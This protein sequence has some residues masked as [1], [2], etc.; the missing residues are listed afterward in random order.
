MNERFTANA[1]RAFDTAERL[2]LKTGGTIG[3]EHLLMGICSV[4]NSLGAYVLREYGVTVSTLSGIFSPSPTNIAFLSPKVKSIISGA[5]A[6]AIK[7]SNGYIDVEHLLMALLKSADCVA[8]RVL[9]TLGIDKEEVFNTLLAKY[10]GESGEFAQQ[11][12]KEYGFEEDY[13]KEEDPEISKLGVDLTEKARKG[14]LDPVIGRSE[15]VE[16]IVQILSRRTKNNPVLIGEPGVGKSA[17]VEGLAQAIVEGKVPETLKGKKI[18]SLDMSSVVAGTKYRGEFEERFKNAISK[19]KNSGDTILFIDEIHTIVGA[20][21]AEGAIDAANILK[22]MLARGE[23]QTIGATTLDEYRK[24]IE[25]DSALERRFQPVMVNPPSVNDTIAILRGIRDKYEAHH[26][27]RITDSAL[28]AAAVLSDRYITDRY[29]PDKAI[30]LID[31]AASRKRISGQITP[32]DLSKKEEEIERLEADKTSVVNAGEYEKADEIKS[33]I[34]KLRN[35]LAKE[36]DEWENKKAN[37][38]L[39][40]GEGEIAEIVSKWTGVPLSKLTEDE[41]KRL[42]NLEKELHSRVVGQDE[43]VSAVANA[44]RRARAGLKEPKRPIGSFIF[45]GPTG[46]GK[47]ELSKALAGALFGDENL[48]IRVDMSEYMSKENVSKLIG[49]APGY[50]GFEEG[51]QL[52]EKVRRK[53]YSV[54][55]FDEIEKA[56]PD[57]FNILLQI[58]DDGRLTDSHCRVVSFKNTVV[59]MTSNV[60]ASDIGKMRR[61]GFDDT[62]AKEREMEEMKEKQYNA[63]R[64]T[65]KPEFLN[66]IDDIIMFH[67]LEKSDIEKIADLMLSELKNR[68]MEHEIELEFDKSAKDFIVEKGFDTEYGA[69]PLRR[70]IQKYVE[71]ELSE[72]ILKGAVKIGDKVKVSASSGKISFKSLQK[73][74]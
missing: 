48:M 42:I 29:L 16:R 11:N 52:T 43:A 36:K 44:I 46:V 50:V 26:K 32:P 13:V 58:L 19:F 20:G 18:F 8:T 12:E 53:P 59:I 38:E 41:S 61:L 10:T 34:E 9:A 47:T 66:R 57:I 40:I 67:K 5:K 3:T 73:V 28:N 25:K 69:R 14:K 71:N 55:L 56:H 68:L 4:E 33:K 23:L 22:P 54:V 1:S 64:S 27:V 39:A 21:S 17:V 31:E 24:Y 74:K 15:E 60:G 30:D 72:E 45:L 37:T 65:F 2:A 62:V 49:S 7:L 35:E 63:L 51:G 70:A 6:F